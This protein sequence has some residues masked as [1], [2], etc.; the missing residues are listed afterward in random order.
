MEKIHSKFKVYAQVI[1]F[2]VIWFALIWMSNLYPP[3]D[4]WRA[5]KQLPLAISGYLLIRFAFIKWI[6]RW[7]SLQGWLI[8]I[9]DLQGTWRGELVSDWVSPETNEGIA[10]IPILLVIRQNYHNLKCTMM[11]AESSSY[12]T[13]SDINSCYGEGDLYLTYTYTNRP[14]ASIRK[15]SEIH[16]GAVIL[17]IVKSPALGLE[18]E[19]WTSRKTRGD[20]RLKFQSKQLEDSF[21]NDGC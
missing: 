5:L 17:K 3:F 7:K 14:K 6:W 20:M 18:G 8:K 4:P 2:L 11:T 13:A 9:P 21:S 15:R 19:Y 1:T 16:D 12:S 10:P